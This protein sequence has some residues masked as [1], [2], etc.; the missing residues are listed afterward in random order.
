MPAAALALV[1]GMGSTGASPA[2]AAAAS[3]PSAP[4][5]STAAALAAQASTPARLIVKLHAGTSDATWQRLVAAHDLTVVDTLALTGA[6]VVD[7]PS[8]ARV[9]LQAEPERPQL[10]IRA[11]RPLRSPP[12]AEHLDVEMHGAVQVSNREGYVVDAADRHGSAA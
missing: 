11:P 10:E 5:D 3:G 7:L 9:Q 2:A 8:S 1:L 6:H 12:S 4:A